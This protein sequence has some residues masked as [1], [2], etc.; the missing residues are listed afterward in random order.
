MKYIKLDLFYIYGEQ[1]T[2]GRLFYVTSKT[3]NI[4]QL[5]IGYGVGRL[6]II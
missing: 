2:C 3:Q 5:T 6:G 4:I 1:N